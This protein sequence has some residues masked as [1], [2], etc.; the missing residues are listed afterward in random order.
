MKLLFLLLIFSAALSAAWEAVERI[1]AHRQIEIVLRSGS[2]VRA[3][4]VSTAAGALVV[5]ETS[6]ERSIPRSDI[7]AVRV[8]DPSRRLHRG[9]LWTAIGAGAGA[10]AGAAG[11]PSC[12]NEGHGNPYVGPGI[13]A[14]AAIGALGFLSSPYRTVYSAE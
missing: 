10:A 6:G 7:R 9:L 8:H 4:F 5:R 3:E 12:P 13:A 14:G 2:R 11:C 1:P